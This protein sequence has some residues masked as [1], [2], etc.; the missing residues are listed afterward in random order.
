MKTTAQVSKIDK[1][2]F[3]LF[4]LFYVML[5]LITSAVLTGCAGEDITIQ[6]AWT[7]EEN[8]TDIGDTQVN[9]QIDTQISKQDIGES[10][11]S[12]Q[13]DT[14]VG[15]RDIALGTVNVTEDTS[16]SQDIG[17]DSTSD[18]DQDSESEDTQDIQDTQDG[19]EGDT[20]PTN[21]VIADVNTTEDVASSNVTDSV[22]TELNEESDEDSNSNEDS[23]SIKEDSSAND[24]KL[25]ASADVTA[26]LDTAWVKDTININDSE[27]AKDTNTVKDV[28]NVKDTVVTQQPDIIT[29]SQ[30]I[31]SD[32]KEVVSSIMPDIPDIITDTGVSIF[33][34][35]ITDM[36][37][38]KSEVAEV[39][40]Q[41]D[42]TN[43]P[44]TTSASDTSAQDMNQDT[45]VLVPDAQVAPPA[46]IAQLNDGTTW[47]TSKEYKYKV[48][49]PSWVESSQLKTTDLMLKGNAANKTG[50]TKQQLV[51]IG[52]FTLRTEFEY[53]PDYMTYD[54]WWK[55]LYGKPDEVVT[56]QGQTLKYHS[57]DSG[58]GFTRYTYVKIGKIG[59]LRIE[60]S[61]SMPEYAYIEGFE[62][63]AL[64]VL[65]MVTKSAQAVN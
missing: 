64:E 19:D 7:E 65:Y 34:D 1:V 49:F 46:D 30:D 15:K 16:D 12:K 2:L 52:H 3:G 31:I 41:P 17:Q 26:L 37:Q 44:D 59:S 35:I 43:A 23:V 48:Q 9:G 40:G 42:T 54:G 27:S 33:M 39:L 55:N 28:E 32:V 24:T 51:S 10:Q 8:R 61:F 47:Y 53:Y 5:V 62:E 20:A 6:G 38:Q 13:V 58:G 11:V 36:F 4:M 57:I 29:I 25:V 50:L 14:Q 60:M 63:K 21:I 22:S 18:I 45:K 56:Y